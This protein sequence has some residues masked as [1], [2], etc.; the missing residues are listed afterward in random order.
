MTTL[1]SALYEL[2]YFDGPIDGIYGAT[3]KDAVRAFQI[4]NNLKVDGVGR[5]QHA[6]GGVLQLRGER[7]GG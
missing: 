1:Q 3:T 6:P 5:E 4:N 7:H 2:G